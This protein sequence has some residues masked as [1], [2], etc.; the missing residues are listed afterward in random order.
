MMPEEL[1]GHSVTEAEG[2]LTIEV[3]AVVRH[4]GETYLT[5]KVFC[6]GTLSARRESVDCY[7]YFFHAFVFY[8]L[9]SLS[10]KALMSYRT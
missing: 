3:A 6:H 1:I 4:K 9:G 8:C 2:G 5:G 7:C 10:I